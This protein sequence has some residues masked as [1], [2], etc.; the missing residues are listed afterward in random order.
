MLQILNVLMY[1]ERRHAFIRAAL[2]PRSSRRRGDADQV[3]IRGG[4]SGGGWPRPSGRESFRRRARLSETRRNGW[5]TVDDMPVKHL[6]AQA[7]M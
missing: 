1:R 4:C 6:D 5:K 7:A 3:K 2:G